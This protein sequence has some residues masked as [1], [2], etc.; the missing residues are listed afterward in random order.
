MNSA[1]FAKSAAAGWAWFTRPSSFRWA[2]A[3]RSRSCPSAASLDPR[4]RQRFQL[5]AQAAALLH[6]EHIVPVFGTGFDQGF[7]YYAMQFIEGRSL[8]DLIRGLQR[9]HLPRRVARR[10]RSQSEKRSDEATTAPSR[11]VPPNGRRTW[12][13][14]ASRKTCRSARRSQLGPADSTSDRR[15]LARGWPAS[16]SRLPWHSIMRHDLGVIHRDIKP[17]NLLIDDRG[18]LW[19]TDFGLARLPRR[20]PT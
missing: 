14:R 4:Q 12:A 10:L 1:S 5:E 17:S 13:I 11:K 2:V 3:L 6:H 19:V 18:Q 8:T 16:G 9:V 15:R 20:T 7:H